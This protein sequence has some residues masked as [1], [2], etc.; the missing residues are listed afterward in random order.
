MYD[1]LALHTDM[2]SHLG[3]GQ[4]EALLARS[5]AGQASAPAVLVQMQQQLHSQAVASQL[6]ILR[7]LQDTHGWSRTQVTHTDNKHGLSKQSQ[8]GTELVTRDWRW[9]RQGLLSLQR[10]TAGIDVAGI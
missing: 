2:H 7:A 3:T 8:N 9:Q 6:Q 1:K 5:A 10:R 4:A